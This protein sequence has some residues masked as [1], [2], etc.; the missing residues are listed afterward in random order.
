MTEWLEKWWR[1]SDW[2]RRVLGMVIGLLVAG[3]IGVLIVL[4]LVEFEKW[5]PAMEFVG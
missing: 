5:W 3:I 4:A 1:E 2:V